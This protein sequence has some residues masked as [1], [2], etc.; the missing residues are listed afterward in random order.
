MRKFNLD[1]YE[2]VDE[3]IKKFYADHPEGRLITAMLSNPDNL[4]TVVIRA[5]A[6]IGDSLKATGLA[7]EMREKELAKTS[8]GKE[9][10][11]VNYTSWV[12]NCETS[13]IG[14]AL[15]NAG[16]HGSKRPSREEMQKFDRLTEAAR[17]NVVPQNERTKKIAEIAALINA[18]PL[19]DAQK[20]FYRQQVQTLSTD[21]LDGLK[22]EIEVD[23]ELLA[24]AK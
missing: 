10:E 6:Y 22:K 15:A 4:D 14:R 9:Y 17:S 8:Y 3:R 16:Y 19:T 12:E 21:K 5:K 18:N 7:C 11:S 1:E 23:I 24:G 20:T 13:A 2:P